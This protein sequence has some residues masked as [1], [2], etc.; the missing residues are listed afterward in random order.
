MTTSRWRKVLAVVVAGLLAAFLA[1]CQEVA[2]P[3]SDGECAA[4]AK[5]VAQAWTD[6]GALQGWKSGLVILDPLTREGNFGSS[7]TA[8][9]NYGNGWISSGGWTFDPRGTRGVVRFGDGSRAEVGVVS[10]E[11]AFNAGLPR[12]SG[13][14][15]KNPAGACA[16]VVL[17]DVTL[18]TAVVATNRGQAVVP[19]WKF[20]FVG[21]P[22][23]VVRVAV[24]PRDFARLPDEI[25]S[26]GVSPALLAAMN[27][28]PGHAVPSP[29]STTLN[30]IVGSGCAKDE[31]GVV[32]ESPDLIVVG[33]TA[34]PLTGA[35]TAMLVMKPVSVTLASPVGGRPI[36]DV[37]SGQVL[38]FPDQPR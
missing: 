22:D 8:K 28:D 30:F 1:S 35:C 4:R 25:R 6:S 21:V 36:V 34:T 24:D 18:E 32:N 14:C 11:A 12:Q 16:W 31:R 5:V 33:G 13:E 10:S 9:A 19:A 20:T 3:A 38:R 27:F 29:S 2:Q 23:P 26:S 15:V 17:K 7:D 37:V